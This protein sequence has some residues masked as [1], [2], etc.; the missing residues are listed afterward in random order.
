MAE[1]DT[2]TQASRPG[3]LAPAAARPG[4]GRTPQPLRWR[5]VELL[6]S[7]LPL[8]LMGVLAMGTWWLV[9]NTPLSDDPRIA[10][11]LHAAGPAARADRGRRAAPL[12]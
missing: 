4:G 8:L 6:S 2:A 12:P 10:A 9:K 3:T 1:A 5:L 7:Y 11:A